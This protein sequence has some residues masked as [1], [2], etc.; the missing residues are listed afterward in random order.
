LAGKQNPAEISYC[1]SILV[2]VM[3]P[4][5]L[6]VPITLIRAPTVTALAEALWPALVYCVLDV[7]WIVTVLPLL[8]FA[9][10]VWPLT[11]LTV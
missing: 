2:A 6:V 5:L 11:L 3:L 4:S 9:T 10:M 7:S 8:D 1:T